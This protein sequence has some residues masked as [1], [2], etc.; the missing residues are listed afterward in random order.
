MKLEHYF[1]VVLTIIFSSLGTT[2]GGG[3]GVYLGFDTLQLFSK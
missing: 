3:E 1:S 2:E